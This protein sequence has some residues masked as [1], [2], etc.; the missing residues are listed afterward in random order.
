MSYLK[1]INVKYCYELMDSV[2]VMV[3]LGFVVLKKSS[4]VMIGED[5]FY[6]ESLCGRWIWYVYGGL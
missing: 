4:I 6:Y 3:F 1:G 5:M 2:G